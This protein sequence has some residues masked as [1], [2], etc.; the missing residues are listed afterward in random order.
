MSI[1]SKIKMLKPENGMFHP[2]NVEGGVKVKFEYPP[3]IDSICA[4]FQI[5][6]QTVFTY[7]DTI[8]DPHKLPLSVDVI[9]HERVHMKQQGDKPALWWGKYLRE[10]A[11]RI[12]QEAQA[13][14]RQY[15]VI[16]QKITNPQK[17]FEFRMLLAKTLSGPLY[18]D[19]TG[20]SEAMILIQSYAQESL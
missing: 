11:F 16:C 5:N 6:P 13:Y 4:A 9:E 17:L 10:P 2:P 15:Q 1:F 7:G 19:A 3:N 14:G 20:R 8:Y 12:D 18:G